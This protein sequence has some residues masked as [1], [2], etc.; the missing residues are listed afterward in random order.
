MAASSTSTSHPS[1]HLSVPATDDDE[2]DSPVIPGE[3]PIWLANPHHA[4]R[5]QGATVNVLS[6]SVGQL[7]LSDL[8]D[9]LGRD[10]M[11]DDAA[12]A[13]GLGLGIGVA[14]GRGRRNGEANGAG[15]LPNANGAA[16][17][18]SV[19]YSPVPPKSTGFPSSSPPTST[20][21]SSSPGAKPRP[22]SLTLEQRLSN[23]D[24]RPPVLALGLNTTRAEGGGGL[25]ARDTTADGSAFPASRTGGQA[26]GA[27]KGGDS[28]PALE[29]PRPL[30]PT[31]SEDPFN[32]RESAA[33]SSTS[34]S[35]SHP[36]LNDVRRRTSP[37]RS[38]TPPSN[39][40][41]ASHSSPT[42]SS[43]RSL[44]P[45]SP[46][47][48]SRSGSSD[49]HM[50]M[51]A[52][53]ATKTSKEDK[54]KSVL[55]VLGF[56]GIGRKKSSGSKKDQESNKSSSATS[57]A[58]P[59][60]FDSED[61]FARMGDGG[62]P[63]TS[64]SSS[65]SSIF[66]KLAEGTPP[67]SS[68]PNFRRFDSAAP[69]GS[70]PPSPASA[71]RRMME[72]GSPE[73]DKAP[74]RMTAFRRVGDSNEDIAP[75][76]VPSTLAP[77][78]SSIFRRMGW[79]A[80]PDL[81]PTSQEPVSTSVP[82]S[83]A[84]AQAQ[85]FRKPSQPEP[86]AIPLA[87]SP[88]VSGFRR[89][90]KA[91]SSPIF[92]P[93]SPS[94]S[95]FKRATE[96][97]TSGASSLRSAKAGL[98]KVG[99]EDGSPRVGSSPAGVSFR[100]FGAESNASPT[101]SFAKV[102]APAPA[103]SPII[104]ASPIIV[105]SPVVPAPSPVVAAPA[106]SPIVAA[107]S[108][109]VAAPS[110]VVAAPSPV[111]AAPSPVVPT[112]EPVAPTPEPVAVSL[113]EPEPEEPAAA[114]EPDSPATAFRKMME[115]AS[116]EL[117]SA[118]TGGVFRK[119]SD[120]DDPAPIDSPTRE[121]SPASAFRRLVE[122]SSPDLVASSSPATDVFKRM[123]DS[124]ALPATGSPVANFRKFGQ[125]TSSPVV[126][127]TDSPVSSFRR[128]GSSPAQSSRSVM[129]A[130]EHATSV[131]E[132]MA[133]EEEDDD[134]DEIDHDDPFWSAMQ[135]PPREVRN[136]GMLARVQQEPFE[137][138]NAQPKVMGRPASRSIS[139]IGSGVSQSRS[140]AS[141][142][143]R[144]LSSSAARSIKS[145]KSVAEAKEVYAGLP[146]YPAP[147]SDLFLKQL[148][149]E[150]LHKH[151][152]S[153]SAFKRSKPTWQSRYIILTSY[154]T[155]VHSSAPIL[156]NL[157]AFK[158]S[159]ATEKEMARLEL[160][161]A[162]IVCMPDDSFGRMYALK[163]TGIVAVERDVRGRLPPGYQPKEDSWLIGMDGVD[164]LKLWMEQLRAIVEDVGTVTPVENP[165]ASEMTRTSSDNNSVRTSV[166]SLDTR[167]TDQTRVPASPHGSAVENS[168]SR[169]AK[170]GRRPMLPESNSSSRLSHYSSREFGRD[171]YGGEDGSTTP[172]TTFSSNVDEDEDEDEEDDEH[173]HPYRRGSLHSSVADE[174]PNRL[175]V[176]PNARR[177]AVDDSP[178]AYRPQLTQEYRRDSDLS[179][180]SSISNLP[181][182][183]PSTPPREDFILGS[184]PSPGSR[185]P[186]MR[187]VASHSERT[188]S[189]S[190]RMSVASTG[191]NGSGSAPSPAQRAR[192]PQHAAPTGHLPPPPKP[193]PMSALPLPP[194][195]GALPPPPP[196]HHG[197]HP[198]AAPPP[199]RPPP[200][201]A[202][203]PPPMGLPLPPPPVG[204]P[205]G[206][207]T[208]GQ[209]TP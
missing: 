175:S 16:D 90:P 47:L 169:P 42:P 30:F 144:P 153:H 98:R 204:S 53:T 17:A 209:R 63:G 28:S 102:L 92:A 62:S 55:G 106:L 74:T 96:E 68:A 85:S 182:A 14:A 22:R 170:S 46:S 21:S 184:F 26:N 160:T 152:S 100:R 194:P 82:L 38:G 115:E 186:S 10:D 97:Q 185:S 43:A 163:V 35:A 150:D 39:S 101:P 177:T 203:P 88:V 67:T 71:F 127:A 76:P 135:A 70:D 110:P 132:R 23:L 136:V 181:R 18:D 165:R 155:P 36:K 158:S 168:P 37:Q 107:P 192:P 52:A 12:S 117:P 183:A 108:P 205:I 69:A 146:P 123:G 148:T 176:P 173:Y 80:S 157:H 131:F 83:D 141:G 9:E 8:P 31:T 72:E 137:V 171:T 4:H 207:R 134:H 19:L 179:T 188:S 78:P 77:S 25:R 40:R 24:T 94:P 174:P 103:L 33:S 84:A 167:T 59:A 29:S 13:V 113:P 142:A 159:F 126:L 140:M 2:L 41:T 180:H 73:M 156:A 3:G 122:E 118:S 60:P 34:L 20:S 81:K 75:S 65:P 87:P 99:N 151:E 120:D 206:L 166:R 161:K 129:S 1:G 201:S 139:S 5:D 11:D 178:R 190:K 145:V 58:N 154:P 89:T 128:H 51:P 116:P 93:S 202:L 147:R 193:P 6:S 95:A 79:D 91:N 133:A 104:V 200:M 138:E 56:G 149:G 86:T 191:S 27:R 197:H 130:A 162:S 48:S 198:F 143:V 112:P 189:Y 172:S 105:S 111:V 164:S 119:F 57:S 66:R 64:R 208:Y 61:I 45:P 114:A 124:P 50:P 49:F 7:K 121:P 196:G 15:Q 195:M 44:A 187:T 54:R 125:A 32:F 199:M 109:V